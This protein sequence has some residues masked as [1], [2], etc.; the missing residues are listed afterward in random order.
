MKIEKSVQAAYD[1]Q[2][3]DKITEWR[4]LCARYKAENTLKVCQDYT[5]ERTLD[6]GAGDG[7][8]LKFLD[9]VCGGYAREE[10]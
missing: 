2:Y 5:F 7:S 4:E 9:E 10:E 8:I 1:S 6:C 3:S